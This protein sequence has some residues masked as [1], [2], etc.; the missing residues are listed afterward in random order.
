MKHGAEVNAKNSA[1]QTP[2][3]IAASRGKTKIVELLFLYKA[4]FKLRDKDGITALLAA[5][6]NGHQDTVRVIVLYGGNIEDTN[7]KGNTISH[8]AVAKKVTK[9]I[10]PCRNRI[11]V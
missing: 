10:I 11:S 5:S 7:E 8:Y 3:Y 6:I 9:F 1:D 4:S 2:L